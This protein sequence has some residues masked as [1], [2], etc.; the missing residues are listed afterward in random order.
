MINH[1]KDP[2]E[3]TSIMECQPRVLITAQFSFNGDHRGID[4]VLHLLFCYHDYLGHAD[5]GD[6][7][8]PDPGPVEWT[9]VVEVWKGGKVSG[10]RWK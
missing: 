1:C 6:C 4:M 7:L 5:G 10:T 2:H 8:S 9:Q 3:P